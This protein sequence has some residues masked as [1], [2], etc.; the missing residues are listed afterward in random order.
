MAFIP[1]KGCAFYASIRPY[2]RVVGG[3]IFD[4]GPVTVVKERDRSYEGDI[5]YCTGSDETVV[6]GVKLHGLM[7][8]DKPTVLNVSR[9]VFAPVGPE[10][11]AAL[12]ITIPNEEG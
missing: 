5:F 7:F 11:I 3:G 12:R 6:V 4:S 1:N 2:D 10:V 8:S 9:C